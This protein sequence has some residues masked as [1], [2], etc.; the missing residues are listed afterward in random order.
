MNYY[1]P[2]VFDPSTNIMKTLFNPNNKINDHTDFKFDKFVENLN[3]NKTSNWSPNDIYS[4]N[5]NYLNNNVPLYQNNNMGLNTNNYQVTPPPSYNTN[6]P[7]KL[8]FEKITKNINNNINNPPKIENKP[9][10]LT[11]VK[12]EV[13]K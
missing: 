6:N 11:D 13:T 10:N 12:K 1:T 5:T 2:P 8:Q 4:N 9:I 7:D 3:A